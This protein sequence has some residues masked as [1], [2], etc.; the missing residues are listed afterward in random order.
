MLFLI[1]ILNLIHDMKTL[2][3][4]VIILYILPLLTAAAADGELVYAEGE[5]FV[6]QEGLEREAEIG[7]TVHTGDIVRTGID[8]LAIIH[9]DNDIEIKLRENTTLEFQSVGN[10]VS[11]KLSDG[12]VFSK[13][14]GKLGRDYSVT[15][16]YAVAGVRGTEFFVA[17]GRKIDDSPDI[18]LCVNEGSVAV[19][20]PDAGD[21]VVVEEG[22]GINIIG[23]IKL[24]QPRRYPWT[25]KLNWN[26]NP[27]AGGVVDKTDLEEA[28]SD[29]LDQD[30]D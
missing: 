24:T 14:A 12:G 18:W 21:T 11:V 7:M 19:F 15:T 8:S 23:G 4:W 25:Q 30:Y 27:Q 26:M 20:I 22:L 1:K 5:I 2:R 3:K 9:S 10:G 6:N 17:V 29:L 13:I 16:Q 28:Y